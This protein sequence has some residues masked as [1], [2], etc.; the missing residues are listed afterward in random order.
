MNKNRFIQLLESK[1]GNVKPLLNETYV[2]YAGQTVNPGTSDPYGGQAKVDLTKGT[3]TLNIKVDFECQTSGNWPEMRLQKGVTFKRQPYNGSTLVSSNQTYQLVTDLSGDDRGT[4]TAPAITYYC[5]T[6]NLDIKGRTDDYKGGSLFFNEN[7]PKVEK[8]F[9][10]LCAAKIAPPAPTVAQATTAQCTEY[11]NRLQTPVIA[12]AGDIQT[13]LKNI[14]Y[15]ITVDYAFGNGT[16]TALGT[17]MYGPAD[18]SGINS[19]QTLWQKM[20]DSGLDVGTTPGFGLKMA[21]A[22][23][24]WINE[25]IP[26]L[27]KT[28]CVKPK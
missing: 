12:N 19:V 18:K 16:A 9:K 25:A 28:K 21:T 10:D 8:A 27:V 7:W 22:A 17:F 13:F 6:N 11:N 26:K 20:K 2:N 14:G 23:A 4:Y 5:Q 1:L 24:K 3:V 15:N